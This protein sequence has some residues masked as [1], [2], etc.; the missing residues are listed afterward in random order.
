MR[1][2]VAISSAI[3]IVMARFE[4]VALALLCL[5]LDLGTN[6]GTHPGDDP[7]TTYRFVPDMIDHHDRHPG[8]QW[9]IAAQAEGR[10]AT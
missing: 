6:S 4:V 1:R 8:W 10:L 5:V 3:S 2:R 7:D 9:R